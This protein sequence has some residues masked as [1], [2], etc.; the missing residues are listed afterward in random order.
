MTVQFVLWMRTIS[1]YLPS[2]RIRKWQEN[3]Q[4]SRRRSRGILN[5]GLCS[6]GILPAVFEIHPEERSRRD[7]GA[8]KPTQLG[9]RITWL[10]G[11]F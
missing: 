2:H 6:A 9:N 7:A 1:L 5:F 3:N 11:R 8:T 4:Q 10:R